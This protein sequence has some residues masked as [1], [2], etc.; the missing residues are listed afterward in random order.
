MIIL[1]PW[2]IFPLPCT[3]IRSRVSRPQRLSRRVVWMLSGLDYYNVPNFDSKN[4]VDLICHLDCS[5]LCGFQLFVC[6]S[7]TRDLL[8][9]FNN[10]I[11]IIH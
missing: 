2:V 10:N 4:L 3:W 9:S 11:I 7:Y 6:S 8:F 5:S 1:S